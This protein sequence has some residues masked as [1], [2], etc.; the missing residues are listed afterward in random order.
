MLHLITFYQENGFVYDVRFAF[1]EEEAKTTAINM[2][3]QRKY[4][5]PTSIELMTAG[6]EPYLHADYI[7]EFVDNEPILEWESI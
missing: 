2:L 5:I 3:K 7:G 6:K 1:S 4:C